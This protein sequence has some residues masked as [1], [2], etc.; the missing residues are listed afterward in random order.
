MLR[1]LA[2]RREAP[3]LSITNPIESSLSRAHAGVSGIVRLLRMNEEPTIIYMLSRGLVSVYYELTY[4]SQVP[5]LPAVAGLL[6]S[7]NCG[8]AS[9]A[10]NSFNYTCQ[11]GRWN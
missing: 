3:A 6:I 11:N 9:I 7:W 1:C 10:P 5:R 4:T 2:R 8:A